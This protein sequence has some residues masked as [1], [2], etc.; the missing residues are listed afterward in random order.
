MKHP[1]YLSLS[2]ALL[3]SACTSDKDMTNDNVDDACQGVSTCTVAGLSCAADDLN[4]CTA[5]AQGCLILSTNDCAANS[6]VCDAS[7]AQPAC[8]TEEDTCQDDPACATA[9]NGDSLCDANNVVNCATGADGCLKATATE[10]A[11]G[12]EVCEDDGT[13]VQCVLSC[14]DHPQCLGVEDGELSC[15][16]FFLNACNLGSDGCLDFNQTHCGAALCQD[17]EEPTSCGVQSETG[18]DCDNTIVVPAS[19]FVLQGADFVTDFAGGMNLTNDE[20][21][22]AT[23]DVGTV[24]VMFEVALRQGDVLDVRQTGAVSSVISLQA[25]CGLDAACIDSDVDAPLSY[26]ALA[27]ETIVVIVE[28]VDLEPADS[29]YRIE[30]QINAE[31]G[32]G[33]VEP[34]ELCDD[35][36][37]EAGDGCDASCQ[38]EFGFDCDGLSPTSCNTLPS[39]GSFGPGESLS[40]IISDAATAGE[41]DDYMI[42]FTSTVFLNGTLAAGGTGD[43]DFVLSLDSG[44]VLVEADDGNEEWTGEFI[45][46]GTYLVNIEL[47][48][49]ADDSDLGYALT[50]DTG[51][52]E[53]AL[54]PGGTGSA[55]GT[56]LV[57]EDLRYFVFSFAQDV[58]LTG[59]LTGTD[60]GD[61]DLMIVGSTNDVTDVLD[62]GDEAYNLSLQAG[63]YYFLVQA[64][65]ADQNDFSL[66]FTVATSTISSLGTF[67]AEDVIE[68]TTGGPLLARAYDHY[69]ITFS[70]DVSLGG[71]L[72]DN[73]TG[74]LAF[75]LYNASESLV[76]T[77]DGSF[78]DV[79]VPAG[80][81]II[82]IQTYTAILGGGD[83]DA[84]RFSLTAAPVL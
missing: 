83:V 11:A 32:N 66:D 27:D 47:Y 19:G 44:P 78:D 56:G 38:P 7:G 35:S 1:L 30:F 18:L 8:V 63:T 48:S 4:T 54:A 22:L 60:G 71:V 21:C 62:D 40:H 29:A 6:Q 73:T 9:S 74:A 80:T 37:E 15:D 82:Q 49:A 2:L 68:D 79:V 69:S 3:L 20:F 17:L 45:L 46:A 81:Y 25:T 50:L 31:C 34:G 24:G 52:S 36:N 76:A 84:Y 5:D 59:T 64:Y 12:L 57:T 70:E 43:F 55:S 58:D 26:T 51:P 65:E 10:C 28:N 53:I 72:E 23:D 77:F 42:T 61:F 41:S 67:A 75:Y 39:L 33:S 13:I 14:E 16:G